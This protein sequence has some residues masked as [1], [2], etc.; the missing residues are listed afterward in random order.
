MRIFAIAVVKDQADVV[1]S[2]VRHNRRLLDALF[3]LDGGSTDSTRAVLGRLAREDPNVALVDDSLRDGR[4]DAL[5]TDFARRLAA[6][7]GFEYLIV[8]RGDEFIRCDARPAL[9]QALAA[10]PPDACG[11]LR[12]LTYVPRACDDHTEPDVV[13]RVTH[14]LARE[15]ERERART[16]V[17]PL[18]L[19]RESG[20]SVTMGEHGIAC[21]TSP[22]VELPGVALARFPARS[23]DQLVGDVLERFWTSLEDP[24]AGSTENAWTELARRLQH[25]PHLAPQELEAVATHVLASGSAELVHDPVP[26]HRVAPLRWLELAR[27]DL[28]ARVVSYAGSR[29]H[30]R[31]RPAPRHGSG[32]SVPPAVIAA[33]G[34]LGLF[35]AHASVSAPAAAVPVTPWPGRARPGRPAIT[36]VVPTRNAAGTLQ[37]CLSDLSAE[38]APGDTMVLADAGSDDDTQEIVERFSREWV[39][40][41]TSLQVGSSEGLAGAARAGLAEATGDLSA[42]VP[43]GV[44]VPRGFLDEVTALLESRPGAGAVALEAPGHGLCVVGRNTFL[45]RIALNDSE[46]LLDESGLRLG[47]ALSALSRELLFVTA[48]TAEPAPAAVEARALPKPERDAPSPRPSAAPIELG[49]G[50]FQQV[51]TSRWLGKFASFSVAR[52]S[53]PLALSFD[54]ACGGAE[55]YD[56]FPFDVVVSAGE[57]SMHVFTFDVGAQTHH[58]E[59]FLEA[60]SAGLEVSIESQATFAPSAGGPRHS[61]RLDA[62]RVGGRPFPLAARAGEAALRP[63]PARPPVTDLRP[64]YALQGPARQ[65]EYRRALERFTANPTVLIELNSRCNF[66]C[67]YCRSS[68][69]TRQKSLMP[70][71]LFNHLL[72]QL[73][74]ITTQDLRL[75]VDGEPTLHP[76]FLEMALD[77]NRAGYRIALAT[78][79]SNLKPDYL[80]IGMA[81]VVNL[82]C[83]P[84]E[85][86][87]RTP[88]RFERYLQGLT[89]YVTAWTERATRQNIVLKVYTSAQERSTPGL[90][91]RKMCFARDFIA[92]VGLADRAEWKED[93]P[94]HTF[95]YTKSAQEFLSLT[96]QPLAEGGLY[97]NLSGAGEPGS[98]LAPDCGFCDAPWK[99]LAVLSDGTISYCCVDVTGETGFT[100]PEDVR[101]RGLKDLWLNHPAIQKD[102]K[103]F[104]DGRVARPICRRCLASVPHREFYLFPDDFPYPSQPTQKRTASGGGV[105]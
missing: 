55:Q 74:G 38:L 47:R 66:R 73:E 86:A 22:V 99:T 24:N 44:A 58:V 87:L 105:M 97:P 80:S 79:A 59:L 11:A 2:F 13:L 12:R 72:G 9:R 65:E 23:A 90:V 32:V 64:P 10:I 36:V 28:L 56:A 81:L 19:L 30:S 102:R 25:D 39:G 96:V 15:R 84:E 70:R 46:A 67:H 63:E 40:Q 16:L 42:L 35:A 1:E 85:L 29:A 95:L 101:R 62:L 93:G 71:Q 31:S 27:P 77:A 100:R 8:L 3:V 34:P 14:R 53:A 51:G 82:S 104:L 21:G 83:S 6:L 92:Q 33:P 98:R 54:L 20:F 61:V 88:M 41:V 18:A 103:D 48:P 89:R 26:S 52:T 5:V 7:G 60:S 68:R 75:H 57:S 91:D 76:E 45:H 94:L 17:I 37:S 69:S 43:S 49:S 4:P 50:F 78:N